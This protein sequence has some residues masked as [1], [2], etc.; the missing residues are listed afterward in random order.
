MVSVDLTETKVYGTG[1]GQTAV[2][3]ESKGQLP[4][5]DLSAGYNTTSQEAL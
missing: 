1:P 4:R 5:L 2:V 3:T